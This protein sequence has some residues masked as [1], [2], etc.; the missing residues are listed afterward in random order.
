[1]SV[2]IEQKG[3]ATVQVVTFDQMVTPKTGK[4]YVELEWCG[5]RLRAARDK[6]LVIYQ[7]YVR[8]PVVRGE[9]H[10]EMAHYKFN[11]SY[12]M[13]QRLDDLFYDFFEEHPE[14]GEEG[15]TIKYSFVQWVKKQ[16]SNEMRG[17]A[18]HI[19]P[20]VMM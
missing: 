15:K 5:V 14:A 18:E 7:I 3:K 10:G 19:L 13:A 11:K 12:D 20:P 1:M 4:P 16:Q 6:N 2:T 9:F 17:W 8:E